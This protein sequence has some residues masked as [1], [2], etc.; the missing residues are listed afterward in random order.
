MRDGDVHDWQSGLGGRLRAGD[1]RALLD[2]YDQMGSFVYGVALRITASEEVA[3]QLAEEVFLQVWNCPE[4]LDGR[5]ST[6]RTRLAVLTHGRAVEWVRRDRA[7]KAAGAEPH[8]GEPGGFSDREE[9]AE[10]LA[11]AGRVQAA[12]AELSPEQQLALEVTCSGG[13]TYETA[14][15]ILGVTGAVVAAQVGEALHHVAGVLKPC[16]AGQ[17]GIVDLDGT[18]VPRKG[19]GVEGVDPDAAR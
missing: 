17:S 12:L 14:A 15:A 11:T 6:I 2:L 5:G 19:R 16:A 7:A 3:A 13:N 10:A 4:E 9:L 1:R 18:D 8:R